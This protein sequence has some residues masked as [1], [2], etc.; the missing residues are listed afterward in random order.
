[1]NEPSVTIKRQHS[2]AACG[3]DELTQV[4]DLP[5]L[6]MIGI[7]LDSLKDADRFPPF[8][9]AM[10]ICGECGHMQLRDC[11]DPKYLYDESFTH[12]SSASASA[13][14]GN[15]FFAAYLQR[16]AG[17]RRFKRAIEIGCNDVQ[18]LKLVSP[19]GDI[20]CGVDPI[21]RGC[22]PEPEGNIRV[23]GAFVEDID[24]HAELDGAPDLIFSS[25]TFEHLAEPKET[26]ER[27][28]E[29]AA[30]DALF[31]IQV[32]GTDCLLDNCR[33]DQISHQHYHQFT[34]AS[35][36]RMINEVGGIYLDHTVNHGYWGAILVAFR[37]GG[38]K[39][40][41]PAFRKATPSLVAESKAHFD[42][43]I[44]NC[45]WAIRDAGTTPIYGFGAAQCLP[46]LA[47]FMGSDLGFMRAILDDDPAR[48]NK[49]YPGIT[50]R[51]VKPE[52]EMQLEEAA[53]VVTA[54]DYARPLVQRISA[55]GAEK[56]ILPIT[57]L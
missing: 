23:I 8:D 49:Y 40:E 21:W 3:R 29:V 47:Y 57:I 33:F 17:D 41:S 27:L 52:P 34:L 54:P 55:L 2:C 6:P 16:V 20:V 38:G 9:Q 12:R 36:C 10:M 56:I 39:R 30:D 42:T 53:I 35:F 43:Q 45:L 22:E 26:L 37:K 44:D 4:L 11:L 50:T 24:F 25:M 32:P 14:S 18:L 15:E 46:T 7:F 51:I 48:Q 1:M 28:I 5:R 31:V 19:I 13:S